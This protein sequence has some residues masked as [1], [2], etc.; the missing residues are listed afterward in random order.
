MLGTKRL[1]IPNECVAIL[2]F[3]D[4]GETRWSSITQQSCTYK[5]ALD[6]PGAIN[7]TIILGDNGGVLNIRDTFLPVSIK[8]VLATRSRMCYICNLEKIVYILIVDFF[9]ESIHG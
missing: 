8:F 4:L 6:C 3:A 7:G 1:D 5:N 9:R 2:F